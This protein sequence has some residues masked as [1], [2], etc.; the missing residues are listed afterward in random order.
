MRIV[1][2][3]WPALGHL[4]PML[5]LAR[6]AQRAGHQVLI[7]SGSDLTGLI[8]RRG[9][10]AQAAGP[11]LAEAY[12]A[13]A[14]QVGAP[15]GELSQQDEMAA[16]ATFLFGAAAVRR[17]RE[18]VP[19]F[20]ASRPDLVVHDALELGSPC[21]AEMLGIR[22][23]THSYGPVVPGSEIFAAVLGGVLAD[24]GL[25]DPIP[26]VL[27]APYLDVCPPGLQPAGIA[28]WVHGMPIRPAP[29]E[30]E[31]GDSL[32]AGFGGLPHPATVYLTLGTITN[33]RP[34]V[35]RAVLEGCAMLEVNVVTST[36][37][38][39]D[40]AVLGPQPANVLVLPYISQALVLPHCS[41]VISHAGAGTMLGA[42]CY[43]LPQLCLPQGTDQPYN[44]AALAGTGAGIVL[45]SGTLR[46]DAVALTLRRLLDEPHY[47]DAAGRLRDQID[48]MP[49]PSSALETVTAA[50]AG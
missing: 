26:A 19:I 7:S 41:A 23:V 46:P 36:G 1:V 18:L 6:A 17:A 15:L 25:P 29:G 11:T 14:T 13:A 39:L 8:E 44:A 34:D 49:E 32:P 4:L 42:L 10:T 38:G 12:A 33:Q 40:P 50:P 24:A 28:P 16:S 21:A 2:S 37:P 43:G 47:R 3:A 22:H 27:A 31:P 35:F 30:V 45:D 9:L 48:G 5:P 20:T